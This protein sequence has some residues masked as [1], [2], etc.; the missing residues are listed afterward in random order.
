MPTYYNFAE[1]HPFDA[2]ALHC[3]S[4][5]KDR[6]FILDLDSFRGETLQLHQKRENIKRRL[7]K[8]KRERQQLLEQKL[9]ELTE[10]A[11]ASKG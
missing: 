9:K 10:K 2:G 5:T 8:L 3:C 11:A 7:E 6:P 4:K 1:A